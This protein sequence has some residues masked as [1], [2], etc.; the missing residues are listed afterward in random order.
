MKENKFDY[1]YQNAKAIFTEIVELRR[2]FH[3]HPELSHKEFETTNYICDYLK[4]LNINYK[5]IKDNAVVAHIGNLDG[6][7]IAL[8]T[9]LDALPIQEETDYSFKSENNGVMHAC[10]HDFHI[11][12]LLGASKILKSIENEL[13]G[14]IK[15]IFQPSEEK[16]PSGAKMLIDESALCNPTPQAVFAQHIMPH[17]ETGVIGI[18]PGPI[19]ASADELYWNIHGKGSHAGTAHLSNNPL[20]AAANLILNLKNST[21]ILQN[22]VENSVLLITTI[23]GGSSTNAIPDNVEL[24][25]T[26]RTFNNFFRFNAHK[27]IALKSQLLCD[28]FQTKCE[29]NI[30]E[31]FPPV[32]NNNFLTNLVE[33]IVLSNLSDKYFR[34]V[35]KMMLAEDFAFY[36]EKFP[37]AFW[38]LGVKPHGAKDFPFLHSSKFCPDEAAM[39]NGTFMLAA[40]AY[41]C[42]SD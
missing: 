37:A 29:L 32:M 17:L 4:K 35:E 34:K 11:A 7:C 16:L 39:L 12:M 23:N 10:G 2:Y 28:L 13:S 3:Q 5:K 36:S 33:E 20:M 15:L 8:R 25:G 38:F 41:A 6:K 19:M 30:L 21:K 1:I 27:E 42:L 18:R 40:M 26:L 14:C 24:K 22:P 9:D 31:G